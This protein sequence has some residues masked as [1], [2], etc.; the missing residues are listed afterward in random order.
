M[1]RHT[2]QSETAYY[3]CP[4][5]KYNYNIQRSNIAIWLTTDGANY[6]IACVFVICISLFIGIALLG[7][8][9]IAKITLKSSYN[10]DI[11]ITRVIIY[12]Y[13]G[14]GSDNCMDATNKR[15]VQYTHISK[16]YDSCQWDGYRTF[17]NHF[18]TGSDSK[19]NLIISTSPSYSMFY[20]NWRKYRSVPGTNTNTNTN[21]NA[22]MLFL[23]ILD[24]YI[25]YYISVL[26]DSA[27]W[28][29]VTYYHCNT[30]TACVINVLL[31]G[32]VGLGV[33]GFLHNAYHDIL[34]IIEMM[35]VRNQHN[36]IG[37]EMIKNLLIMLY[38]VVTLMSVN[39]NSIRII[40]G[41]IVAC[42]LVLQTSLRMSKEWAAYIGEIILEAHT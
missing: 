25:Y 26:M 33:G 13:M 31:L 2:S 16:Y 21:T 15:A 36:A 17:W 19:R 34:Q 6:I 8:N 11:D 4:I 1:W 22:Q 9:Y 39:D 10:I 20:G 14:L 27:N 3:T 30:T 42:Q 29:M 5:C 18:D 35:R 12:D 23:Y 37:G 24:V 38:P 40:L 7:V 41:F 32:F 28:F